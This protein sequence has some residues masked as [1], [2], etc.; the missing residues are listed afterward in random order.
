MAPTPPVVVPPVVSPPVV[1]PVVAPPVVT[2]PL[3]GVDNAHRPKVRGKTTV[4]A[5]LKVN[6]ASWIPRGA[7]VTYGWRANGKPIKKAT[8]SKL[9]LT[10]NVKGKKISVRVV[11]TSA[12][13]LPVAVVISAGRVK[14]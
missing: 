3:T 7:K 4:G 11:A 10:K 8:K 14:G 12:G 13:H 2:L 5:T 1:P 6:A 9:K